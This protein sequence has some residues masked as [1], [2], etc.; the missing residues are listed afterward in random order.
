[1]IV[2]VLVGVAGLAILLGLLDLITSRVWTFALDGEGVALLFLHRYRWWRLPYPDIRAAEVMSL[3][4]VVLDTSLWGFRAW[5]IST[6]CYAWH[7]VVLRRNNGR[8]V[9][10]TPNDPAAFAG[11]L[12]KQLLPASRAGAA[13]TPESGLTSA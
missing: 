7:T 13:P 3:P 2:G 5:M 8:A 10:I 11:Q 9:V 12:T 6:R 4:D 1:M